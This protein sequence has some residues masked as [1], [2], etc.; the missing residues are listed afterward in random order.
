MKINDLTKN[1]RT[2]LTLIYFLYIL[3]FDILEKINVSY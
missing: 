1:K 2:Y 3:R